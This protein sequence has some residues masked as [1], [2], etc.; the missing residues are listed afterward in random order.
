[1]PAQSITITPELTGQTLAAVLRRLL[2]EASWSQVRKQIAQSTVLVN[3]VVCF[4][5][6]RRL[7]EADLVV[8]I[9]A[10]AQSAS[11]RNDVKLLY[12]DHHL[13]VVDKPSGLTTE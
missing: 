12:V 8:L 4:D 3:Q 1:M 9:A 6:A 13:A 7:R 11:R 5:A 10:P 2:P